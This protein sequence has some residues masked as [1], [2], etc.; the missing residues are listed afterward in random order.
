MTHQR[1]SIEAFQK[2]H[3][4]GCFV[5]PNAWDA[6]SAILLEKIGFKAIASTSSGLSLTLGLPDEIPPLSLEA[7]LRNSADLAG[8]V[9]IPVSVDFQNGYADTP[10]EVAE[11]VRKCLQTGI[12]GLSIEDSDGAR[13]PAFYE[14]VRAV[15]RIQAARAAIDESGIPA[16]LVARCEAALIGLPDAHRIILDRFPAY[17]EAGADVLF[18]P[19]TIDPA[20]IRE[21]VQAA[22]SKPVNVIISRAGSGQTVR[23]LQDL[24][25]RRISVGSCLARVAVGAFLKSARDIFNTGSFEAME[26]AA[27]FADLRDVFR[28]HRR[29]S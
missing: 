5:I 2:L 4:S 13:V 14:K 11:N 7:T 18:S 27:P 1:R 24:G 29:P 22:G 23:S 21:T 20:E 10:D 9:N 16:M 17:A 25:V 15:E 12:A 6:G 26:G 3:E 19:L 28:S 8:A